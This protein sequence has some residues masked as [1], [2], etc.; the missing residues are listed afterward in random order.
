MVGINAKE[1]QILN[2]D[3]KPKEQVKP[4]TAIISKGL[5]I[6]NNFN[7]N[8]MIMTNINKTIKEQ[9]INP[10]SSPATAKIK[11]VFAE[12]IFSFKIP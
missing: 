8:L 1:L 3:C 5:L 6:F 9:K 10:N 12:G 11:S 2:K 7:K 4:T